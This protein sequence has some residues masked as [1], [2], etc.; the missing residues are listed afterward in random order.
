MK[1][2]VEKLYKNGFG[3]TTAEMRKKIVNHLSNEG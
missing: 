3:A 1:K 2:K